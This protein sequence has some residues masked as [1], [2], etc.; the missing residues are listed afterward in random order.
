[1]VSKRQL[2]VTANTGRELHDPDSLENLVPAL[3]IQII[4]VFHKGLGSIY[5]QFPHVLTRR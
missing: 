1:M 4:T 5:L 3:L 2:E